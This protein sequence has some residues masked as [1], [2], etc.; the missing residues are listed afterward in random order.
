MKVRYESGRRNGWVEVTCAQG[1]TLAIAG[2]AL[3]G[4]KWDAL[5]IGRR[6]GDDFLYVGTAQAK[7]AGARKTQY[8]TKRIASRNRL[9]REACRGEVAASSLRA[10]E[11]T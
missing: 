1:K 4:A 9:S 7:A 5:Y 3:G 10:C 2:Y 11:K 6:K 8:Y